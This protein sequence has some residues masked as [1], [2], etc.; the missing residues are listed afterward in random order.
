MTPRPARPDGASSLIQTAER[1]PSNGQVAPV[2]EARVAEAR[3]TAAAI[4]SGR[5]ICPAVEGASGA[6]NLIKQLVV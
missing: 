3:N 5:T 2:H 6:K 1:P 4:S